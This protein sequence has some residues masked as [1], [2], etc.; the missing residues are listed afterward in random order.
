MKKESGNE[1]GLKRD[2]IF[3]NFYLL[4]PYY[5]VLTEPDRIS[6]S[7]IGSTLQH[8]LYIFTNIKNF[9]STVRY[10][11]LNNESETG[12]K[13]IDSM[14]N[15]GILLIESYISQFFDVRPRFYDF[16]QQ[17]DFTE[18]MKKVN[19]LRIIELQSKEKY[20]Y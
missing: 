11:L 10:A 16:L 15:I 14:K 5:Q 6:A 1:G 20:Y 2:E 8:T 7:I 17:L 12:S 4:S 18:I 3:H 9:S 19:Q 13:Y